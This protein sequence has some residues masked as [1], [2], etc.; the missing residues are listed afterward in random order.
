[1]KNILPCNGFRLF[2]S[3]FDNPRRVGFL[4]HSSLLIFV[5]FLYFSGRVHSAVVSGVN[6]NSRS[7]T[8]EWFEQG[9][10]KGKEL[11][12]DQILILNPDLCPDPSYANNTT[13]NLNQSSVANRLRAVSI[14]WINVFHITQTAVMCR[15]V[16]LLTP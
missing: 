16:I 12:V 13:A 5:L 11:P 3:I 7:V 15:S 1:M 14:V 9:E 6:W 10:T 4:G 8:V 2:L